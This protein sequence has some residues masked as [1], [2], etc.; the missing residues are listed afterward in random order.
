M[1]GYFWFVL[2]MSPTSLILYQ[3]QSSFFCLVEN[4]RPSLA[5]NGMGRQRRVWGADS[6]DVM[7]PQWA[8]SQLCPPMRPC[9][10]I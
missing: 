4:P 6:G 3:E 5:S 8:A 2:K 9:H 10:Q 7:L 1:I